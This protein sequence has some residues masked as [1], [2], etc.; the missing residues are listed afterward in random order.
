METGI[1]MRVVFVWGKWEEYE[2]DAQ[3]WTQ[4]R[5][6]QCGCVDLAFDVMGWTRWHEGSDDDRL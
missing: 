3:E 1:E 2:G 5:G 4:W 6:G